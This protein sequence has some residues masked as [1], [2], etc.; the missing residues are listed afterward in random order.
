MSRTSNATTI[1]MMRNTGT[2]ADVGGVVVDVVMEVEV[3]K[4]VF[5][6]SLPGRNER[7]H[8]IR[9][10]KNNMKNN[11]KNRYEFVNYGLC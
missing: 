6:V 9:L 3:V 11:I 2:D 8:I 4:E 10:T 5:E 1:P 7:A